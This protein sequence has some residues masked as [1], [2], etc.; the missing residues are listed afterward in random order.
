MSAGRNRHRPKAYGERTRAFVA[1]A[2]VIVLFVCGALVAGQLTFLPGAVPSIRVAAVGYG[3]RLAA[4]LLAGLS[5][6]FSAFDV[7]GISVLGRIA[8]ASAFGLCVGA[9]VPLVERLFREKPESIRAPK[10][11]DPP[12]V[13]RPKESAPAP[14]KPA[15]LPTPPVEPLELDDAPAPVG[16][17]AP[18]LQAEH[19][20]REAA[21]TRCPGCGRTIPGA[22]GVRYCMVCDPDV[23]TRLRGVR[24]MPAP[25]M[26]A[27]LPKPVLFGLYGAARRVARPWRNCSVNSS[28][29]LLQPPEAKPVQPPPPG[30]AA[31]RSAASSD[32]QLA[33]GATKQM[34]FVQIA[35]DVRWRGE[36]AR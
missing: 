27:W 19:R 17:A 12:T 25:K 24:S 16:P 35:R 29:W 33:Q 36:G 9:V 4:G 6:S 30:T 15:P 7:L 22:V 32:L 11:T 23:L 5:V 14:R 26:L 18:P 10:T 31:W 13:P 20:F 8:G 34:L 2:L 1:W 3:G 21:A 28:W